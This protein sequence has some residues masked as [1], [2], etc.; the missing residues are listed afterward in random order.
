MIFRLFLFL[1]DAIRIS[2]LSILRLMTKCDFNTSM[3]ENNW[4]LSLFPLTELK[5]EIKTYSQN[6]VYY[7][8]NDQSPFLKKNMFVYRFSCIRL[9]NSILISDSDLKSSNDSADYKLVTQQKKIVSQR[10]KKLFC[11]CCQFNANDC[12]AICAESPN[13]LL[14]FPAEF[15]I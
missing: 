12:T 7:P 9:S 3:A 15:L 11:C 5:I 8:L 13:G 2:D 4:K 10:T 14:F 6:T 1:L